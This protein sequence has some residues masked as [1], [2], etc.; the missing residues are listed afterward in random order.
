VIDFD[1]A[2]HPLWT[3]TIAELRIDLFNFTGQFVPGSCEV[4][5]LRLIAQRD[6]FSKC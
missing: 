3:G 1:F 5:W 2:T 6:G 4:T